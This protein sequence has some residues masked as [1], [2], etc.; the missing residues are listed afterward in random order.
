M[1]K[2]YLSASPIDV[3]PEIRIGSNGSSVP[4]MVMPSGLPC[5]TKSYLSASPIDVSPE[6]RIGSNGSS[7]P[8]MVMPS[9]PP[10]LT[11]STE[12]VIAPLTSGSSGKEKFVQMKNV[13]KIDTCHKYLY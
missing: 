9:G 13:S 11:N 2:S 3:S 8:D 7:V 10:C 5:L 6:I 12:Y 1:S 4:H